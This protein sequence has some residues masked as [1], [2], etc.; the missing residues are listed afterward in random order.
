MLE[1]QPPVTQLT[2]SE[3]LEHLCSN[4]DDVQYYTHF[5]NRF[6]PEVKDEC[7]RICK[8]RKL[9]Q[10]IGEQIAHDVFER[11]RK[12]K[13]FKKDKVR[14]PESR[15]GIIV[16][17]LRI[18]TS[19]FNDHYRKE[20]NEEVIHRTYFDNILDSASSSIDV[21][22]LKNKKEIALTIFSKLNQNEQKVVL[23]DIQHKKHKKYLPDDVTAEL[24]LELGV[25]PD[26][27]RK[28]RER[29]IKT[30]KAAIDEINQN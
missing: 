29:A 16:Y 6:L 13:S 30:I 28:I 24:A 9:N 19:L 10:D 1:T 15:K 20:K 5:V 14:I 18:A 21:K 2:D 27:I 17:L 25:K 4:D 26:T 23:K 22:K 12:Y 3:L 7:K 11:V 8:A